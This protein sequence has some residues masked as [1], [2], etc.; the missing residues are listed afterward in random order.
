MHKFG[1][2]T[3]QGIFVGYD[4]K[5]GGDWIGDYL[6]ADWEEIVESDTAREIHV[7]RVRE[8]NVCLIGNNTIL[9]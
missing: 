8:I 4:Q 3:L 2:K 7:H 5:A 6:I 9:L 1:S